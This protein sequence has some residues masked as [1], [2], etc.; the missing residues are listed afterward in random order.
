MEKPFSP[1]AW[2]RAI[3]RR[4]PAGRQHGGDRLAVQ[5]LERGA[6][7]A[8]LAPGPARRAPL[9]ALHGEGLQRHRGALAHLLDREASS[10][11]SGRSSALRPWM[12]GRAA[13]N[14]R[15]RGT[16]TGSSWRSSRRPTGAPRA[17]QARP[18]TP[19][20]RSSL[21]RPRTGSACRPA[22][23]GWSPARPP[24]LGQDRAHALE[25]GIGLAHHRRGRGGHEEPPQAEGEQQQGPR[26][27]Q[28]RM[29]RSAS[30]SAITRHQDRSA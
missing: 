25:V 2:W 22:A 3:R 30:A 16:A 23:P 14:R 12:P 17:T 19:N 29:A 8:Q 18:R 13:W 11:I 1:P 4:S 21:R 6:G 5:H 26:P 7:L 15:A 27:R 28:A 9:T 24:R 20:I 10:T